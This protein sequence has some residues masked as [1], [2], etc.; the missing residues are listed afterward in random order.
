MANQYVQKNRDNQKNNTAGVVRK[1]RSTQTGLYR[2][3]YNFAVYLEEK[4]VPFQKVS[5]L[6]ME[7]SFEA[8][9]E[10]GCNTYAYNLRSASPAE[11]VLTLERGLLSDEAEF[12][13]YQPGYHLVKGVA[14]YVLGQNDEVVKSYYLN[15]CIIQK[16]SVGALNASSSELVMANIEIRYLTMEEE[17]NTSNSFYWR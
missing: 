12:T 17:G 9:Q 16:I 4:M 15:G 2:R 7:A 6:S 10:G 3:G 8:V 13:L 11:H 14:V 1:N 5:G